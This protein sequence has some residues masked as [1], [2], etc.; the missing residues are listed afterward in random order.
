VKFCTGLMIPITSPE[1]PCVTEAMAVVKL[2]TLESP[3][4]SILGE[5]A[6][7]FETSILRRLPAALR[8]HPGPIKQLRK[9]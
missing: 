4:N 7:A 5:R 9:D 8:R 1:L 2:V 6:I 3:S